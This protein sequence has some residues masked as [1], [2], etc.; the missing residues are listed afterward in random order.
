MHIYQKNDSEDIE[1]QSLF[2]VFEAIFDHIIKTLREYTHDDPDTQIL[3]TIMQDGI[4]SGIIK[5]ALAKG[6]VKYI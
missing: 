2:E 3:L 6:C 5:F 1:I 4:E